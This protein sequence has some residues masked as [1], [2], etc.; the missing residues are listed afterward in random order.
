MHIWCGFDAAPEPARERLASVMQGLYRTP[1][2]KFARY[3]PVGSPE[4]VAEQLQPYVD[5]GCRSFNLLAVAATDGSVIEQ[6]RRVRE[7]LRE[8]NP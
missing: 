7:L 6:T 4:R 5:A 8:A 2:E 1:F 3:C